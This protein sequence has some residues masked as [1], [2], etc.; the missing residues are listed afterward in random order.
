MIELAR[1]PP[2]L[3]RLFDIVDMAPHPH[4]DAVAQSLRA[5]KEWRGNRLAPDLAVDDAGGILPG[6]GKPP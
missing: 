5:W 3:R 6:L 2:A 4:Q 1:T